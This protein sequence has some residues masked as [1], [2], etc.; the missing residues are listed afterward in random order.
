MPTTEISQALGSVRNRLS[1]LLADIGDSEPPADP[2]GWLA[3]RA[4]IGRTLAG[5]QDALSH[6]DGCF[7]IV[8]ARARILQY[9]RGR[10]GEVVTKD[11]LQGVAGISEW[12]RRVRELREDEGWVIHSHI[13]DL[14]MSPGEYRLVSDTPRTELVRGWAAAKE[15]AKLGRSGV[16]VDPAGRL[17]RLLER[18][19]P[20][21]VAVDQARHA[22]GKGNDLEDCIAELG[23]RGCEVC[24][25][26]GDDQLCPGGLTLG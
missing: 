24:R 15:I 1:R 25:R 2:S 4:R 8:S 7:G 16:G 20:H 19:R 6:A 26:T 22:I 21:A 11:A 14:S 17:L 9:M 12:A 23:R 3:L 5:V 18:V 13:T 10:L